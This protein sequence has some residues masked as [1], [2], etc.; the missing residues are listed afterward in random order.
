MYIGG[1]RAGAGSPDSPQANDLNSSES[2]GPA[3]VPWNGAGVSGLAPLARLHALDQPRL[4]P[5]ARAVQAS[6]ISSNSSHASCAFCVRCDG[7]LTSRR[8]I[9]SDTRWSTS[10]TIDLTGG[11][12]SLT[13]RSRIAIGASES[14]NGTLP[15][16]S[17]N[18][19]QPTEYRSV[20]G[21]MSCAI[22]CS[23]AM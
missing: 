3:L 20:H 5:P 14:W 16:N 11:I 10:G 4:A 23:G 17:S 12:G 8:S 15:V 9:Q 19:M 22:A 2:T 18:A 13:W 21:P 6:R 7:S 1:R